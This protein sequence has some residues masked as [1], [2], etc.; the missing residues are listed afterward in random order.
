M[1]KKSLRTGKGLLSKLCL[2]AVLMIGLGNTAWADELTVNTATGTSYYVPFYSSPLS[3][4]NGSGQ[5]II[6]ATSL[7]SL[8]DCNISSVTFE[9]SA[10]T[11]FNG[12]EHNVYLKEVDKTVFSSA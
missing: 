7:T 6:P 4:G 9:L 5:F 10:G 3:S 1:N 11:T 8:K 2:I 12:A